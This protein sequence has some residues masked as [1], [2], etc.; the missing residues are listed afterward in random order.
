MLRVAHRFRL[1]IIFAR[2]SRTVCVQAAV[3]LEGEKDERSCA[4]WIRASLA[5]DLCKHFQ[6]CLN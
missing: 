5:N 6:L 4:A 1:H 3:R 2:S